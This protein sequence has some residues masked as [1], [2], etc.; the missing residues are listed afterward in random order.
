MASVGIH[1]NTLYLYGIDLVGNDDSNPAANK[2][3]LQ[4][5][6]LVHEVLDATLLEAVLHGSADGN[7]RQVAACYAVRE[8]KKHCAAQ[9]CYFFILQGIVHGGINISLTR[10]RAVAKLSEFGE[11][12]DKG[13]R[14]TTVQRMEGHRTVFPSF[15]TPRRLL[16]LPLSSFSFPTNRR[17]VV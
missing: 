17:R 3:D 14:S 10:D 16:P 5:P 8:M 11:A 4:Q 9:P 12:K 15:T 1:P 7:R 6:I 13:I 2:E